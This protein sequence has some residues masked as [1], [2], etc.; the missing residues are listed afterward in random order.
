MGATGRLRLLSL[1][2]RWG[3]ARLY[4]FCKGGGDEA[5]VTAFSLVRI[6]KWRVSKIKI[7]SAGG[8]RPHL[9]KERKGGPATDSRLLRFTLPWRQGWRY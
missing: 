8:M 1:A 3:L 9:Y 2:Y 6:N 7:T 4:V 5:G